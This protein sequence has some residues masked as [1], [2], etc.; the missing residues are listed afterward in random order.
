MITEFP[1][2]DKEKKEEVST[3]GSEQISLYFVRYFVV[4][5][6]LSLSSIRPIKQLGHCLG[7]TNPRPYAVDEETFPHKS[8]VV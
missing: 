6:S 4:S 1:F 8:S 7:P 2:S 3:L 5:F